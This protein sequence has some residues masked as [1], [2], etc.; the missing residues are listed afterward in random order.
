M[1]FCSRRREVA[2][3]PRTALDGSEW[4]GGQQRFWLQKKGRSAETG[5]YI[6]AI[7]FAKLSVV[8]HL[9]RIRRRHTLQF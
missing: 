3:A 6:Q 7:E 1:L 2:G 9:P 8:M 4:R 5:P